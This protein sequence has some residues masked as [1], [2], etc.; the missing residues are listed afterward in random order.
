MLF[1]TKRFLLGKYH[2]RLA[3]H[4]LGFQSPK[5]CQLAVSQFFNFSIKGDMAKKLKQSHFSFYRQNCPLKF[6]P[7]VHVPLSLKDCSGNRGL[8]AQI[9]EGA[10]GLSQIFASSPSWS[11]PQDHK[12]C[13]VLQKMF[14][15][16]LYNNQLNKRDTLL[17]SYTLY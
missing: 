4:W 7:E 5:T 12:N 1:F 2:M 16:T 9:P 3:C 14:C 15:P 10:K 13:H 17:Y 11:F 6:H 8:R